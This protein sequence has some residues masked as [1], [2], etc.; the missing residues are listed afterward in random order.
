MS[1]IAAILAI[2][3]SLLIALSMIGFYKSRNVFLSVKLIFICNIYGVSLL[4]I[5]LFLE[6]PSLKLA[7]KTFILLALNIIIS[8]IVNYL[9]VKKSTENLSKNV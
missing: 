7:I 6:N 9:I 5:G 2:F 8:F 4:L 1:L 3:G